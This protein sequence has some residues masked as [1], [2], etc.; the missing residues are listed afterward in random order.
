M[1][2][3]PATPAQED[4]AAIAAALEAVMSP[5]ALASDAAAGRTE[6]TASHGW[7]TQARSEGLRS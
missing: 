5:S 2:A 6:R 7:R 4:M 3:E 1:N